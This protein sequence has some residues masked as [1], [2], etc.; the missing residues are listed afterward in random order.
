MKRSHRAI[1]LMLVLLLGCSEQRKPKAEVF[2]EVQRPVVTPH[3][4]IVPDSVQET[5]SGKIQYQTTDKSQWEVTMDRGPDGHWQYGQ[6]KRL[7]Q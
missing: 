5:P 3:G 1:L 7:N 2:R 4:T 6:P